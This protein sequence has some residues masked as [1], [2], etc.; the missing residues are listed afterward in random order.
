LACLLAPFL[1]SYLW[2]QIKRSEIRKEVKWKMIAGLDKEELVFMT[3]SIK[4]SQEKL[5]WKHSKEFEYKGEWY[6]VVQQEIVGDSIRYHLWWDHE[7]TKLS[8]QLRQLIVMTVSQDS[9]H[10]E[11]QKGIVKLF[12]SLFFK[13]NT[14]SNVIAVVE[15]PKRFLS[16]NESLPN[17][18]LINLEGPPPDLF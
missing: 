1:G 7:E 5:N 2:V 15:N 3:F 18:C 11:N 4:E 16:W 8:Q 10:Q 12:K 13:T 14:T 9:Q 6:D 17:S